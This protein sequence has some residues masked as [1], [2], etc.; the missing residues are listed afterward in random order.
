MRTVVAGGHGKVGRRV[1]RL[2]AARGDEVVA[3]VRDPAHVDELAADGVTAVV[4]DLERASVAEV[5]A[6]MRGADAVVF[7]AGAGAGSGAAR[8]QTVDYAAAVLTAEAAERAGVRRYLQVSA[9]GVERYRDEPEPAETED[10]FEVYL[11]AKLAA[12]DDLRARDLE[13]TVLRPGRL[14]DEPGRGT[15]TLE[16]AV[17]RADVS[18]DDVA[19]V[20]VAL[21]D[22]PATARTVLELA[23][24]DTSV[25]EA[26]LAVGAANRFDTPSGPGETVPGGAPVAPR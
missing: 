3:L 2:L 15:V 9:M 18:R 17:A 14:T 16:R 19:A 5:V 25:D 1:G 8:K 7:A 11:R 23:G 26:V 10:V 24:G 6:V 20:V 13:W 4:V 21:L 12:E 22:R